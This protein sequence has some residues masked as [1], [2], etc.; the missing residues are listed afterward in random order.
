MAVAENKRRQGNAAWQKGGKSPNPGGRPKAEREVLALART[1]G[2]EALLRLI[3]LTKS[4]NE[5]VALKACEA[6]L[7]R[8]FGKPRQA[9]DLGGDMPVLNVVVVP[10]KEAPLPRV[11]EH[12]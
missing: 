8:G 11:I 7:D 9:V 1:K 3:A 6:V 5:S 4:D 2:K 10:A 12:D